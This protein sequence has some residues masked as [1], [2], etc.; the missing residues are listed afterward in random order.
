MFL[1]LLPHTLTTLISWT[2]SKRSDDI[3]RQRHEDAIRRH[4]QFVQNAYE[5][6][7]LKEA[8]RAR[9][10][11]EDLTASTIMINDAKKSIGTA[12]SA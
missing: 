7:A 12:M 5:D 3:Q 9:A 6:V 2:Q 11:R 10:L 8:L 1:Q 4:K